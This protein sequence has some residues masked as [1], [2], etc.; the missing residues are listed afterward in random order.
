LTFHHQRKKR[1]QKRRPPAEQ[2]ERS[3]EVSAAES[4]IH[5]TALANCAVSAF[6]GVGAVSAFGGV[7]AVSAFGGVGAGGD[8]EAR[9][10]VFYGNKPL[11]QRKKS[12]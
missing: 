3:E 6:G 9:A 10:A 11:F 4:L 7:G 12:I 5:G 2:S 1:T 8:F